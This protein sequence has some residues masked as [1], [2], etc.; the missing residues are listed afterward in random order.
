[1][2]Y[3]LEDLFLLD[4][5]QVFEVC[6]RPG[7]FKNGMASTR[8][9][10]QALYRALKRSDGPCPEP[11][12]SLYLSR[13]EPRIHY[14]VLWLLGLSGLPAV[15]LGLNADRSFDPSS[16]GRTRLPRR[17]KEG[18]RKRRL[19]RYADVDAIQER[20]A[21]FPPVSLQFLY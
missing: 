14:R 2:L 11:T 20:A 9:K 5:L 19:D 12:K 1:M 21:D 16:N 18:L 4:F 6:Y 8:R 7:Y 13:P 3:S 15:S 17:A 10:I